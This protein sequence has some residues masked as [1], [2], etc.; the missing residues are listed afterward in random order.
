MH[1]S[2]FLAYYQLHSA[3]AAGQAGLREGVVNLDA[4]RVAEYA[5]SVGYDRIM[6]KM[7]EYKSHLSVADMFGTV[8]RGLAADN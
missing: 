5:E 2:F 4:E 3:Q 7:G 6:K 1:M 8:V